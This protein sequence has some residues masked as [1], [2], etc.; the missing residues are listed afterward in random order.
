[1]ISQ[2]A[3][4]RNVWNGV[5]WEANQWDGFEDLTDNKALKRDTCGC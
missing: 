4:A 2:E 3:F 5:T 1:M